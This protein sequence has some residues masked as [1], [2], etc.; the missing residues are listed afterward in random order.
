MLR[1]KLSLLSLLSGLLC[2]GCAGSLW[3]AKPA[4][5]LTLDKL[6]PKSNVEES[7]RDSLA[8]RSAR[9]GDGAGSSAEATTASPTTT[10][11]TSTGVSTAGPQR[12]DDASRASLRAPAIADR[13]PA[14]FQEPAAAATFPTALPGPAPSPL[15]VAPVDLRISRLLPGPAQAPRAAVEIELNEVPATKSQEQTALS[16]SSPN[17]DVPS[18]N[19]TSDR[20]TTHVGSAA[21][22]ANPV[23]SNPVSSNSVAADKSGVVVASANR[24]SS[25]LVEKGAW[26]RLATEARSQLAAETA[27]DQSTGR[28]GQVLEITSRLLHLIVNDTEQAAREIKDLNENEREFWKHQLYALSVALDAEGKHVESRRAALA[29]RELRSAMDHLQNLS[30]LDVRHLA[31]CE[32]VESYGRYTP[33]K[34][35]S[36]K[37]GQEFLL[38]VEIDNFAVEEVGERY[39]TELRA[40]YSLTDGEGQRV[41]AV[42]PPTSE[43]C[44]NRRR[45]YFIAYT[46][47]VP[48]DLR[49]GTYTLQLTVEDVIG[50]KSSQG[51]IELRVR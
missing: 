12:N 22:A 6:A 42:L 37:P 30:T 49:P 51:T 19:A 50:Q 26:R 3:T 45:D 31:I 7:P 33:F 48:R 13:A 14:A 32:K 18:K 8:T 4:D 24:E 9:S 17:D 47:T 36:F 1:P 38:Y 5:S 11:A 20:P 21:V 46:L 41:Q 15:K 35:S 23:S 40:E 34:A 28:D 2:C 29:L 10:T 39:R 44:R 27:Q 25:K 16:A 43:E